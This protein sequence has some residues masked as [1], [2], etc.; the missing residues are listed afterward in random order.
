[1]VREEWE[2]KKYWELVLLTFLI[3][4]LLSVSAHK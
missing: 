2:S 1:M 3:L 4:M